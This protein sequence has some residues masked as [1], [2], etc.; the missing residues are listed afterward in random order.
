MLFAFMLITSTLQIYIMYFTAPE[1]DWE[2]VN[3]SSACY[4][5]ETQPS[6]NNFRCNISRSE[7]EFVQ[8]E[9]TTTITVDFDIYCESSWLIY[10]SNSVF[11]L[12]KFFGIFVIGWMDGSRYLWAKV[13]S[14]PF[15][16]IVNIHQVIFGFSIL[17]WIFRWWRLQYYSFVT[18]RYRPLATNILWMGWV[19]NLCL[20][21][22]QACYQKREIG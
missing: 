11:Y 22:M 14:F 2:C 5:N 15:V 8:D 21:P 1:P 9:G 7:W 6:T 19:L 13:L 12:S 4:L 16:C 18:P 17:L 20:L 3:G 10:M